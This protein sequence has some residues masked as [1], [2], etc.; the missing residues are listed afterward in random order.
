MYIFSPSS[1]SIVLIS[2][3][4]LTLVSPSTC[5][6]VQ[7]P[8]GPAIFYTHTRSNAMCV[9]LSIDRYRQSSVLPYPFSPWSKTLVVPPRSY[10][11]TRIS[12]TL[13]QHQS[14]TTLSSW[15]PVIPILVFLF[16]IIFY[17]SKS[18]SSSK[19]GS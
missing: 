11:Y 5:S 17:F 7:D 3:S 19:L 2:S 12:M 8:H 6:L 13:V 4:L 10:M 14:S 9:S 18:T 1:F 16:V 15:F